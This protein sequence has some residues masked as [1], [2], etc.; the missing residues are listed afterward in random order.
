[1]RM[2]RMLEKP[3]NNSRVIMRFPKSTKKQ[4]YPNSNSINSCSLHRDIVLHC[5]N[6]TINIHCNIKPV[7][8][9]SFI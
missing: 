7:N 3:F 5:L 9:D 6:A 1:M 2:H 4:F 8:R